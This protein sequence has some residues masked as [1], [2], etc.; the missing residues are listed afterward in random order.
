VDCSGGASSR[1]FAPP[2]GGV[3]REGCWSGDTIWV[4]SSM[5]VVCPPPPPQLAR[6]RMLT[7][8]RSAQAVRESIRSLLLIEPDRFIEHPLYSKVGHRAG[9]CA[10]LRRQAQ[11]DIAHMERS[12]ERLHPPN[13]RCHREYR[14]CLYG[15]PF[16]LTSQTCRGYSTGASA[17]NTKGLRVSD[18][19]SSR[20]PNRIIVATGRIFIQVG[21]YPEGDRPLGPRRRGACLMLSTARIKMQFLVISRITYDIHKAVLLVR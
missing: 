7:K 12:C 15:P 11:P 9:N 14:C 19:R 21:E 2:G 1:T 8:N 4:V 5:T 10:A 13:S 3:D 17:C 6:R 18:K 16:R 20:K